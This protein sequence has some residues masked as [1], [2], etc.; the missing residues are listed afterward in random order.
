MD[1]LAEVAILDVFRDDEDAPVRGSR[2]TQIENDIGM[3]CLSVEYGLIS[4]NVSAVDIRD[5]DSLHQP[6]FAFEVLPHVVIL[7]RQD[8]LD[9]DIDPKIRSYRSQSC[10]NHAEGLQRSQAAAP[11]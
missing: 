5:L 8:L 2:E 6:P 9:G 4:Y 1:V 10:Q 3:P 11:L 7:R